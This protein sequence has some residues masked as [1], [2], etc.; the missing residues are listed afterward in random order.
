M[1]LGLV[2]WVLLASGAAAGE[3]RLQLDYR[4]YFG[5]IHG[6]NL[7]FAVKFD[8]AAYDADAAYDLGAT[9][10]AVQASL[11][12]TGLA[13][14]AR[15]KATAYSRGTLLSGEVLPVR[16]GYRSK[17]WARRRLVEL[18]FDAGT[19][20][21]VRMKPRKELKVSSFQL[22]G[23][24]DPVGAFLAVLSRPDAGRPCAMRIPVFDGRRLYELV[25]EMDG[26][27]AGQLRAGRYSPFTGPTVDCRVRL[28]KKA[29]FKRK[30]G[31]SEKRGDRRMRLRM[32]RVFDEV[33]TVPV[34]LAADIRYGAVVVYLHRARLTADGLERELR[35]RHGRKRRR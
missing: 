16:A 12:T 25:G 18:G 7:G 8:T 21:L 24:L 3:G 11:K 19:P 9:A 26:D 29:G 1:A 27:G 2:V 28:V 32:G 22:K 13:K 6:A 5:S 23:A 31:D 35:P 4:L 34:R 33:P 30:T 15:W 14:V 10:Y 20:R 17:S